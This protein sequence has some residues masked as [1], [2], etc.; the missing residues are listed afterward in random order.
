M[1][2]DS[3]MIYDIPF[4]DSLDQGEAFNQVKVNKKK[5]ERTTDAK[6]WSTKAM[7]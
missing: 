7:L 4:G 3:N 5:L 6:W 1:P 2:L